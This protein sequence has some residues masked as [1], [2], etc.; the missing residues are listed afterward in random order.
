MRLGQH[1]M[2]SG[3]RILVAPLDWGLGHSTRCIPIIQRLRELD[4]RPVI[5]AD[6]GPLALLRDAFPDLPFV[7]IPG[8]EV[9]YAKGGSQAWA[10]AK[11][12]P[13]MLR[14][15]REEHHLFLN[16]RRQSQLDAV[17]SDQ[18]FGLRADGLPSTIITHQVFPF[19]P[20]AQG[21]LRR[22]NLHNIRRFDRCWIPDNEQAPG[23][24]GELSPG[25]RLRE[26]ASAG[27][28]RDV[29]RNARYIGPVS[30]MDPAKAITPKKPYRIVC[31]IS[32][33]EPQRTL[34]EEELMK[35]LPHISGH[36]LLL[37]G[38]PEPVL[39]ETVGTP[40][41]APG[42]VR[43]LSHLRGDALT[44]ALL[45][46]ELIVSRTGYTTLMDLARI[47]RSAL[48]IPTP[49]QEEQEY[50]GTLH[51]KTGR[52]VVQAQDAM[53]I[54]K[55][56]DGGELQ[57]ARHKIQDSRHN[58]Q[59]DHREQRSFER[60]IARLGGTYHTLTSISGAHYIRTAHD[61][62]L[63]SLHGRV[64]FMH[65]SDAALAGQCADRTGETPDRTPGAIRQ[66]RRTRESTAR[67]HRG[68][69]ALDHAT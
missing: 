12:F 52:F 41:G 46:A 50:L 69:E 47:G 57:D 32:G 27:A 49:G 17:I 54:R 61:A 35:Q 3:A 13:A 53:D 10:M 43:R 14:S 45:Q 7:R 26:A 1:S 60:G 4:A 22:F 21:V 40:G 2:F 8:V 51:A 18:R 62:P 5:G 9:R 63:F 58:A 36:H 66:A 23:L 33:P 30:R 25:P 24:A 15:V 42:I 31:V 55:V 11:Q 68:R 56:L 67:P 44:G 65:R 16:L 39:D 20:L 38:K 6:K 29:P 34:L 59:A 19:T 48:V 28:K 37:R 64:F